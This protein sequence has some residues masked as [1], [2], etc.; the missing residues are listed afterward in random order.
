[1]RKTSYA[2]AKKHAVKRLTERYGTKDAK[3]LLKVLKK[4]ILK[5]NFRIT[6]QTTDDRA[7]G[8]VNYNKTIYLVVYD[9]KKKRII[10]ALPQGAKKYKAKRKEP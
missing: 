6:A 10:T 4:E 8:Y 9:I 7:K 3:G 2:G 5:G 1:M